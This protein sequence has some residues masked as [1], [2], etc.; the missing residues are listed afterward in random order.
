MP[1][2]LDS[3]FLSNL[4]KSLRLGFSEIKIEGKACFVKHAN[5]SDMEKLNNYYKYFLEKSKSMGVMEEKE[6]VEILDKEGIWTKKDDDELFKKE[7]ELESL[8]NTL[9]NLLLE[10]EKE[11]I[12]KRIKEVSLEVLKI[13]NKKES[14]LKN[15]AEKYADRKSNEK[16][17]RDCLFKTEK[18]DETFY[19][20]EEFDEIDSEN[21]SSLYKKYNDCLVDFSEKNLK[22]LSI[23]SFFYSIFNLYS[24]D[25]TRFFKIHPMDLSFYQINLLNY[26]KMFNKIFEN[27]EIP[28]NIRDDAEAIL[29]HLEDVKSKKKRAEE[30]SQKA[31]SSDGFSFAK[32]K[33][34]DL[35]NMG[36]DKR[37]TKDIH[38]AAKDKGGDLSMEDFMQMHKK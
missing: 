38:S 11:P 18:L 3:K 31:Q 1:H 24:D 4:F 30:V 2:D 35:E 9:K 5:T 33:A 36:V 22:Q 14:L 37:G 10:K 23:S 13:K 27:H 28:D 6:L 32:A 8:K 7:K 29:N 17:V 25:L 20:E 19:T 26:G 16:F 34:K 15:T 12:E 21:L